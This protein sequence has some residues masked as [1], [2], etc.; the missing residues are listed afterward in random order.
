MKR[1]FL[2]IVRL[3]TVNWETDG[4]GLDVESVTLP[5]ISVTC[6]ISQPSVRWLRDTLQPLLSNVNKDVRHILPLIIT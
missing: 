6:H 3:H 2:G 5:G 1:L 4:F